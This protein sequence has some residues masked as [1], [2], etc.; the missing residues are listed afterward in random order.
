M[1]STPRSTDHSD[2]VHRK[3]FGTD[4][5]RGQVG[6]FPITPETCLKIAQ[7]TGRI[8]KERGGKEVLIGKDTRISGYLLESILQ[9]GFIASGINV[10]LLGV[11]PTP[12]IAYLTRTMGADLGI[13]ISASHNPY[14][15]NGIKF[16][17]QDGLK[18]PD[19][20]E[21]QIELMMRSGLSTVQGS[22]LGK[23]SRPG[24][25]RNDYVNFCIDS[26]RGELDLRDLHI[27]LDCAHGATYSIAPQVF[28]TLGAKV[29]TIGSDPN[30][31]NINHRCGSTD[32]NSLQREVTR[33]RADLGIAFDGDGDRVVMVD[34]KGELLDGDHILYCLARAQRLSHGDF[35][36]VVGT[37]M[38]NRGLETALNELDIPFC[39]SDVGDRNVQNKMTELGWSLGGENSGHIVCHQETTTGDGIVSALQVLLACQENRWNL[40]DIV[41]ELRLFPQK[42]VNVGVKDSLKSAACSAVDGVLSRLTPAEL[43]RHRIVVR[44]S[45]TES[46]VRVLVEGQDPES[47]DRIA[48]SCAQAITS[49]S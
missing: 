11:I 17:D 46:V 43:D 6:Q 19:S 23:A 49:M 47:V 2:S 10:G 25:A 8:V 14:H 12:A 32:C 4:G 15:D 7:I 34:K 18:L 38:T 45:G 21:A 22:E 27:V 9:G 5:I 40:S 33:L 44:P 35:G 42:L 29:E 39:R 20:T 37:V 16:F 13:A 28:A 1:T 3:L 26:V 30:G 41:R 36:G 24:S 31:I 48:E